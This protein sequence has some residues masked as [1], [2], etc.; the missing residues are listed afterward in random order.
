MLKKIFRG[1]R[2]PLRALREGPWPPWPPV[3]TSLVVPSRQGDIP[4][5]PFSS[6]DVLSCPFSSRDVPAVVPSR[7]RDVLSCSF[8]SKGRPQLFLLVRGTSSVVPSRQRDVP[9]CPFSGNRAATAV[10]PRQDWLPFRAPVQIGRCRLQERV[11]A[12][13][14]PSAV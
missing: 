2:D 1:L 12:F 6:G 13:C 10:C 5:C 7:Q 14:R 4:S 11:A 3:G 8:S 9:S